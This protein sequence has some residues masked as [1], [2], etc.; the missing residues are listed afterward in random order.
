[1]A[2][3]LGCGLIF[4]NSSGALF[5]GQGVQ[6]LL[7]TSPNMAFVEQPAGETVVAVNDTSGSV[8]TLQGLINS[9]RT[10]NP[11][12]VIVIRLLT[13]AVYTVTTA[14][15]WLS[16]AWAD[17]ANNVCLGNGTGIDVNGG[18]DNVLL[19][20]SEWQPMTT[21]SFDG[22]GNFQW[23]NNLNPGVAPQFFMLQMP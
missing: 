3:A 22:A 10:A 12:N 21:N 16:C 23:T 11:T 4:M 8:A 20:I 13:N 17:V 5:A 15:I 2:V 7:Y 19:P 6:R 14:G 9:A 18:D 1:M